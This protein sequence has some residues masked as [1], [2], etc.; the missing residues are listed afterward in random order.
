MEDCILKIKVKFFDIDLLKSY[1][2]LLTIVS[3]VFSFVFIFVE[4][5]DKYK[6]VTGC[7]FLLLLLV[8][9]I[10]LW[11]RVNLLTKMR[12]VINNSTVNIKVGDIFEEVDL[13]VIAFN[14]YFDTQVDNRIISDKTING[15]FIKNVVSDCESLDNL[16]NEN[17]HLKDMILES[18]VAREKGKR[19]RYKLGT[20]L[21]LDNYLI[22]AFSKFD[23]DNR[24]Y[25]NMND[26]VNFLLNFWNEVDIVYCGRSISIPLFGSGITRIKEYNVITDQE[27]LELLVWSFKVSKIKFTYPSVITIVIHDSKKEKINFYKLKGIL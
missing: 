27:L 15:I 21:E 22:T 1:C 16:I 17:S 25:L 20:I 5:P 26:Y 10:Y 11:L 14:E 23:N 12:L 18:N 4:I 24:A 6:L 8:L 7:V 19:N 3:L 2:S 9:Y 13:K